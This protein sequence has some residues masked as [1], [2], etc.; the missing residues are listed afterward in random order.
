[1]TLL[2]EAIGSVNGGFLLIEDCV[3]TNAGFV[4][5]HF[6]KRALDEENEDGCL[7]LLAFANPFSHYDR[8]LRKLG[9]NLSAHKEKMK[10]HFFDVMK[11]DFQASRQQNE[12]GDGKNNLQNGLIRLFGQIHEAVE[13]SCSVQNRKHFT[14]MIDD[15]SQL[16]IAIHGSTNDVLDFLHYCTT[17]NSNVECSIIVLNHMDIYSTTEVSQLLSQLEYLA[18]VILKSE[19]L[20]TGLA[21]DVHG[22]LTVINKGTQNRKGGEY[23]RSMV[24]NFHFKV[25]ENG[26]NF[27]Y[28]GRQLEN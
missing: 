27:F 9:C 24:R 14:I 16:E 25:K 11:M 3:E 21:A 6:I 15:L 7:I 22:Q 8:I 13:L 1:M 23:S 18:N 19:S 12:V 2:D 17:I 28:P 5:H 4:L 26:V 10:L 20:S